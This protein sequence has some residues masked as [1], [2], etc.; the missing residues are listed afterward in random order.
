M[1]SLLSVKDYSVELDS[2]KIS[3]PDFTV[4]EGDIVLITGD[5]GSGKTTLLNSIIG[6]IPR[7]IDARWKGN[8]TLLGQPPSNISSRSLAGILSYVPQEP[9]D[10]IVTYMVE[11]EFLF[12]KSLEPTRGW[13]EENIFEEL[14]VL[15]GQP[16]F[17][18]SGGETRK[19]SL[20]T[21]LRRE[22]PLYI[23]DEPLTFL[24]K[25]GRKKLVDWIRRARERKATFIITEHHEE[26]LSTIASKKLQL[27]HTPNHD[28][29]VRLFELAEEHIRNHKSSKPF[30][31]VKIEEYMPPI[32]TKKLFQKFEIEF[33]G[34]GLYLLKGP[35]GSGKTTLLKILCGM[36]R[37]RGRREIKGKMIMVPDNPLLY[38]TKPTLGEE[39][40]DATGSLA[41]ILSKGIGKMSSGERRIGAILS[42]FSKG[43]NIVLLDEP[44]L[45]LDTS[46]KKVLSNLLR[47][48]KEHVLVV[49]ATHE[50]F[51]D[52]YADEIIDLGEK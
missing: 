34:P 29:Y 17:T 39:F 25:E 30:I 38:Y 5:T 31:S 14:P 33:K 18:L 10:A 49:V 23:L 6:V 12:V 46:L 27:K 44:T 16:V 41:P 15:S 21:R 43:Y 11:T 20:E 26:P 9:W 36:I 47:K 24:D 13:I 48:L 42:A 8:L 2:E 1:N 51:L 28:S 32:S 3:Y 37:A 22:V 40:S 7:F 45:G 35:N 50:T 52:I 4:E 19:L